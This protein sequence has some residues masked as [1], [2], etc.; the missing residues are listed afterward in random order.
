MAGREGRMGTTSKALTLLDFF[1]RARPQVGLSDLA[2]L[3]GVNKATCFRLMTELVDHGLAEQ[4]GDSREYRI[5]PAVLRLAA[6]REATVPLRD[7]AMPVVHD[8]AGRTGETAHVSHLVLG[9]L[10]TLAFAYGTAHATRVMME[11]AEFLPFHATSSGLALLAH[12]PAPQVAAILSAPLPQLT[13]RTPVTPSA[14]R[15]RIDLVQLQGH[16]ET[17]GTYEADVASLAL[18]LFDANGTCFGS[19][20]LAAPVARMTETARRNHLSA[21][22]TAARHV[23]AQWGAHPP[24]NLSALWHPHETPNR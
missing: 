20:A 4:L 5:G 3:S 23:M 17:E 18:P 9:R 22:I 1:T 21:L 10:T 16:A 8:L 24:A 15:A 12:L 6:L 13:N 14:L 2:R 19:I 11:D 7:L